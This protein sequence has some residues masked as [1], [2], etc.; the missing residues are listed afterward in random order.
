MSGKGDR[1][2]PSSVAESDLERSWSRIFSSTSTS[3]DDPFSISL[4]EWLYH[5]QSTPS[6]TT[7]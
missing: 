1:R 4:R 2:R 7:G 5:S 6:T 3:P